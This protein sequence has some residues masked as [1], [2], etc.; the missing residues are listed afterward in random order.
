MYLQVYVHFKT[1]A[2]FVEYGKIINKVILF[3]KYL[4]II[5]KSEKKSKF[6]IIASESSS[7]QIDIIRL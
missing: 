5:P 6:W 3:Q 2:W 7:L 1:V 4:S